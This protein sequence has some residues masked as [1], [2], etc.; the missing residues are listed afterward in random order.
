MNAHRQFYAL[1]EVKDILEEPLLI[2]KTG[3]G[4]WSLYYYCPIVQLLDFNR[5]SPKAHRCP[6]CG[7]IWTGSP[8]D[9][10]WS[11]QHGKNYEAAFR[12]ALLYQIAERK[13]CADK[14]IEMMLVYAI[15]L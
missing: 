7:K 8:C 13:D 12:M 1:K 2:P 9:E 5:H 3:I 14:A 10:S 11:C 15:L 6:V 4:N